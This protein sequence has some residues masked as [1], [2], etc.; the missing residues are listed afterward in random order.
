LAEI[1]GKKAVEA[2]TADLVN[3]GDPANSWL[4]M[5][6]DQA[7]STI[8]CAGLCPSSSLANGCGLPMPQ[9]F[10]QLSAAQRGIIRDWIK[11]GATL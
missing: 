3:S 11:G 4:M 6:V 9:G 1:V 2:P 5:K 7:G 10:P 8:T